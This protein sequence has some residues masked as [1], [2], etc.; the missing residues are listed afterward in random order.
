M[1]LTLHA[2]AVAIQNQ[3]LVIIGP[4]GSGKSALALQLMALGAGLVADDR[5]ILTTTE[6]GLT[7]SC[8][9]TIA[10]LIE[11]RNVGVLNADAAPSAPVV[12]AVDLGQ[13]EV[14]RSPL[15]HTVTWLDHTIPL[16]WGIKS[17]HFPASLVQMLTSGRSL[18]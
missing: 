3:A 18:R 17:P 15:H 16:L 2:T 13:T 14:D 8:P 11:A 10:G 6:I 12:L 9:P 7:A 5:V 4:S 1:T